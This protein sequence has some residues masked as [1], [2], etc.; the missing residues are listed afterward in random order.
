LI[1][2]QVALATTSTGLLPD[3]RWAILAQAYG[4]YTWSFLLLA[5]A[6]VVV[7][8]RGSKTAAIAELPAAIHR[9]A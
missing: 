5:A 7:L 9:A 3:D 6:F 2:V 4:A 8:R 1:A